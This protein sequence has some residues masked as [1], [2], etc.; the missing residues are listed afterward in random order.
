VPEGTKDPNIKPKDRDN[1]I[2]NRETGTVTGTLKVRVVHARDVRIADSSSSDP[3][4]IVLFPNRKEHRTS[5]I[6][7]TLNPIWNEQF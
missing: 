1:I 2:K 6:S 3:Y 5:T 7:N 4:A